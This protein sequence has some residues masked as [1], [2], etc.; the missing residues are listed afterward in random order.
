MV[1][2]D[3]LLEAKRNL[4]TAI[5]VVVAT[6]SDKE[7]RQRVALSFA[8]MLGWGDNEFNRP[9]FL[10]CCGVEDRTP[11]PYFTLVEEM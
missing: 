6:I 3:V 11:S 4:H 7:I 1:Y 9:V 2:T 8:D 5:A 10:A